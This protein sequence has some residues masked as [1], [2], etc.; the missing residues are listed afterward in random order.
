[1]APILD[2]WEN[3]WRFL[4]HEKHRNTKYWFA[5]SSS[6]SRDKKNWDH[7]RALSWSQKSSK[8]FHNTRKTKQPEPPTSTFQV[9]KVRQ[10]WEVECRRRP[11]LLRQLLNVFNDHNNYY[12]D[13]CP[14]LHSSI[15]GC[16]CCRH[17][18]P[19]SLSNVFF[20]IIIII[21]I[22]INIII[23]NV[24]TLSSLN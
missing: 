9:F 16:C 1:M 14:F 5:C 22:I 2:G 12:F 11:D 19:L 15:V 4:S 23:L 21:I 8:R 6:S 3:R 20:V 18:I 13:R 10:L 7:A 17:R 24:L